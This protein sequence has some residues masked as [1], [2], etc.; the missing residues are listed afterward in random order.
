[1]AKPRL[2]FLVLLPIWL[3]WAAARDAKE[4]GFYIVS[5]ILLDCDGGFPNF[6]AS[7]LEVRAVG[8]HGPI[9]WASVWEALAKPKLH[10]MRA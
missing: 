10:T 3:T 9:G 8:V 2:V 5:S 6:L 4:P 1:M 7:L